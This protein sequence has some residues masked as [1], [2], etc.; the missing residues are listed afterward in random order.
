MPAEIPPLDCRF[1]ARKA[2]RGFE[3][4]EV[5]CDFEQALYGCCALKGSY[6]CLNICSHGWPRFPAV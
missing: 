6:F 5:Y 4:D 1:I 2:K 3:G